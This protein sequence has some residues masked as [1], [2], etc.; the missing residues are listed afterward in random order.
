MQN[1]IT[2]FNNQLED[3]IDFIINLCHVEN[4]SLKGEMVTYK[5]LFNTT[6]LMNQSIIIEKY[7][8]NLLCYE[9]QINSRDEKFFLNFDLE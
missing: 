4:H 2:E 1:P 7:I 8:L 3:F 6:K 9:E 5:G